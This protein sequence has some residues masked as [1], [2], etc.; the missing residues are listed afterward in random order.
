MSDGAAKLLLGRLHGPSG[1]QYLLLE[2][3]DNRSRRTPRCRCFILRVGLC[4]IVVIR[5]CG[6]PLQ[7]GGQPTLRLL[8]C[9]RVSCG[10]MGMAGQTVT[11][12]GLGRFGP[13]GLISLHPHRVEGAHGVAQLGG[14]SLQIIHAGLVEEELVHCWHQRVNDLLRRYI[15]A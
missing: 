12:C 14:E 10:A 9:S 8:C 4:S 2:L 11:R 7:L 3:A 5:F 15:K 1:F 6:K 13:C